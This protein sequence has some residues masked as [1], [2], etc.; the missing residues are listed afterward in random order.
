MRKDRLLSGAGG[1]VFL[2]CG[3]ERRNGKG[4]SRG[5]GTAATSPYGLIAGNVA[6]QADGAKLP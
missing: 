1:G 2:S 5:C 6:V 4:N 3:S